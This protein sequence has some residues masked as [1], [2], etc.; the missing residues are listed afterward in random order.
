[1]EYKFIEGVNKLQIDNPNVI[2]VEKNNEVS[3]DKLFLSM[4]EIGKKSQNANIKINLESVYDNNLKNIILENLT[5]ANYSFKK[6]RGSLLLPNKSIIAEIVNECRKIIDTP[7][8]L[9]NA[10]ILTNYIVNQRISGLS[11]EILGEDELKRASLNGILAV[12]QGSNNQ[13]KMLVIRYGNNR[14]EPIVLIGKGIVFDSGGINIKSGEFVDMKAD[15]TGAVYAWGLIKAL[16]LNRVPGHYIAIL[17]LAENMPDGHSMHPG[18][19][20]PTCDGRTVEISN[21]DAEGRLILADAMCWTQKNI[22]NPKLLIDLATLTGMAAAFFGSMGTAAMTN[23]L[24]KSYL[25]RLIEI[26]DKHHEYY[27]EVPLHRVFR[28]KLDSR[29]A[30]LKNYNPSINAGTIMAGMFLNEFIPNTTPWIHLDI[31]GVSYKDESTGEP[32]LSLY[33]FLI[34]L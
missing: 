24:G 31:A 13:A 33:H 14:L 16:A 5:T 20:Y 18:D 21:T 22:K 34:N 3:M 7:A 27:W 8:N 17:P 28:S 15:K 2:F 25:N 1:M 11:Y 4:A 23:K 32:M 19:I 29:V 30:D 26:G 12:N 6:S 9:M 10:E